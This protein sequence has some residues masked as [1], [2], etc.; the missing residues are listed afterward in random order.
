M[1]SDERYCLAIYDILLGEDLN[2]TIMIELRMGFTSHPLVPLWKFFIMHRIF[3]ASSFFGSSCMSTSKK[4]FG[5]CRARGVLSYI[6][7]LTDGKYIPLVFFLAALL[8]CS[9]III[10]I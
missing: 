7:T 2:D 8:L 4:P 9:V 10:D 5:N 1:W 3:P 6:H